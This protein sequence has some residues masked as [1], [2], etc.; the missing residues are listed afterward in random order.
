M[1]ELQTLI[2]LVSA[3][4]AKNEP[5]WPSNCTRQMWLAKRKAA[6]RDVI[7]FHSRFNNAFIDSYV[8]ELKSHGLKVSTLN[9]SLITRSDAGI[10][11]LLIVDPMSVYRYKAFL[12]NGISGDTEHKIQQ[13]LDNIV[14]S[15]GNKLD[16]ANYIALCRD[17]Y[18]T[19]CIEIKPDIKRLEFIDTLVLSADTESVPPKNESFNCNFCTFKGVCNGEDWPEI[20]CGTCANV[21]LVDGELS[22]PHGSSVCGNHLYHPQLMEARGYKLQSAD[23]QNLRLN[24]GQFVN[25]TK[26][27]KLG[28]TS[29]ELRNG[30]SDDAIPWG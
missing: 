26:G 6:L 12:K 3:T 30:Q 18:D 16:G 2:N 29:E 7:S 20:N 9:E 14:G 25:A 28:M 15:G 8:N 11:S 4:T 23:S 5:V 1:S 13:Q 24:Y 22:C 10:F 17:N 27:D 21:S 19:T